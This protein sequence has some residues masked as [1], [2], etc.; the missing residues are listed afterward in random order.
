MCQSSVS[1]VLFNVYHSEEAP[2]GRVCLSRHCEWSGN[3]SQQELV[4]KTLC[5]CCVLN[6]QHLGSMLDIL[7]GESD[8]GG[9]EACRP[10]GWDPV[11]WHNMQTDT[12]SHL[13][14][15]FFFKCR[16]GVDLWPRSHCSSHENSG[17]INHF[18]LEQLYHT[19]NHTIYLIKGPFLNTLIPLIPFFF[20][21]K[22]V[23]V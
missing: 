21:K 15:F 2:F 10:Q 11:S 7:T 3:T 16:M 6:S 20:E 19:E 23:F 1:S 5:S 14:H 4:F 17:L 9:H 22:N 8:S 12:H 13:T 18:L